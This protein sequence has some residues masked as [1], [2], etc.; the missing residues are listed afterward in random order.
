MKDRILMI[1]LQNRGSFISGE[2]ISREL[3]VSR[4]AVWKAIGQLREEGFEV[5]SVSNRG[6]RLTEMPDRLN[7]AILRHF[8][9]TRRLGREIELHDAIG[10]TNTRAKELAQGGAVHGTLVAAEEQQTGRGRLGRF[11]HSPSGAGIW[12]SL[13]LRPAF[14]P[15]FAPRV[16]AL[17]GLAL[18]RAI[19]TITGLKAAIKWPNDIIIHSKKACGILTEMQAEPDLI[20][21]V[22]AGIGMN[23]N[24]PR[25]RFPKELRESATSLSIESGQPVNRC[26]LMAAVL[27]ELE[28]LFDEY[29]GSLNFSGIIQEY[30]ENCVTLGRPV[31]VT[32]AAGEWE[33]TA[34]D[35]TD[36]CELILELADGTRRTVLSGD[37]SVRGI[38]GYL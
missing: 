34:I 25:H 6:Y 15:R 23:V 33:G 13:I 28:M 31:R 5:D 32:S 16:T 12:M 14:P 22:I 20:E 27:D 1:L 24:I 18:L 21:Y 26:R 9:H 7:A 30:K 29:E 2:K 36:D 38:A 19:N 17:A 35:L 11:W 37:V 8:L 10:S 4:A 3:G